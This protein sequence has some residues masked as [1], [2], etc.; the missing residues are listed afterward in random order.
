ML[1][2][3]RKIV[4]VVY[5]ILLLS[6]ICIYINIYEYIHIYIYEN[7]CIYDSNKIEL[8]YYHIYILLLLCFA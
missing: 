3:C 8:Y 1:Y 6:Y 2:K 7:I 4:F 5:S